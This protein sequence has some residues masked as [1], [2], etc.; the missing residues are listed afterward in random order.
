[1]SE[2]LSQI[3]ES[4]W[5]Q[6][7]VLA[8]ILLAGVV[9]GLETSPKIMAEYGPILRPLDRIII[10]LFA[11]EAAMKMGAHGSRPYR[12]FANPWNVFDFT[13]VVVCFLPMDSQ[14]AA[15]LR[16]AR[17]LRVLRLVS[18]VPRLQLLVATLLR[19]IPS[20]L[21]V[22]LLLMVLFYIYA[23]MGV[24]LFAEN[25]PG[26]FG[27]LDRSMLSLFR[28]VTL[29]NWT[30]VMYTQM[31]G[32]DVYPPAVETD[33]PSE[34]R[35]MP[36]IA[37]LYFASF[38]MLGTL[39]MLNLFIGVILQSMQEAQAEREKADRARHIAE[40]GEATIEDE[41]AHLET[42]VH[43]LHTRLGALRRRA[44]RNG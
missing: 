29:D 40:F 34:P 7:T 43:K 8:V 18:V 3:V 2:V 6:N 19:S 5:F 1:M 39:I 38:V 37:G 13:I 16:L 15:V 22:G 28:I 10:W 44:E 11:I 25:D 17:V 14:Y 27:R 21:Y 24:F 26:H 12:Y 23:V 32:A 41:I 36:G 35:A 31:Y 4:K 30:E 9:V 33:E 20:M 42:M